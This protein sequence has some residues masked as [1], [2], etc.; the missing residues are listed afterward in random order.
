RHFPYSVL[1]PDPRQRSGRFSLVPSFVQVVTK[2]PETP[3]PFNGTKVQLCGAASD[4]KMP[5]ARSQRAALRFQF[6]LC[7]GW[8]CGSTVLQRKAVGWRKL[9]PLQDR[10]T[11]RDCTPVVVAVEKRSQE[12]NYSR[13]K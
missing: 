6:S 9:L 5:P 4:R 13:T 7:E 3:A 1:R 12:R 2:S 11:R 8:P 10:S